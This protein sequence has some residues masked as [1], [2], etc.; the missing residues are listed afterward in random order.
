MTANDMVLPFKASIGAV[1]GAGHRNST[2]HLNVDNLQATTRNLIH[3]HYAQDFE[4]L[5]FS[6]KDRASKSID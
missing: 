4:L 6:K 1:Q 3:Q 2:A 5:G